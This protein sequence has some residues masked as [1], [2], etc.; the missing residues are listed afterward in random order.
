MKKIWILIIVIVIIIVAIVIFYKPKPREVIKIGVVL[1]LSGSASTYGISAK[2]GIDLALEE[3]NATQKRKIELI[4]ED[5][6]CN[7]EKAVDAAQK[8]INVDSVRIIIG[9]ICSSAAL[10]V[11]PIA[12]KNK[13]ILFSPGASAPDYK[14]AGDYIFRNRQDISDEVS[15]TAEIVKNF[16]INKIAMIYVNNDYGVSSKDIFTKR[17]EELGGKVELAESYQQDA[18]D[19]RTQLTKIKKAEPEAMFLAGLIKESATII[20]Q[21]SELGLKVRIFSTIG[22]EGKELLEIAGPAAEGIIYSA[23]FFDVKST[24]PI[25]KEFINRYKEKYKKDPTYVFA[26]N[27]YD[28]LEILNSAVKKCDT[29]TDCIK[30]QLYKIKDYPGASGMTTFDQNG[31]VS[32]PIM[33]KTIKNGQFVPYEE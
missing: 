33:I 22:V 25:V 2:E 16:N 27:G 20:K 6:Q 23:P 9:H 30:D 10:A 15:K 26:A 24:D 7:P 28:A 11:A 17:F 1:P 31:D 4:Y 3:L 21:S 18:T 13:V 8:L 12:E 19:F 29:N 32:K 5:D 14:N